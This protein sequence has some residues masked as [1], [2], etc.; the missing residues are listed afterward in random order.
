MLSYDQVCVERELPE[1]GVCC[2]SL[3]A[4][5]PAVENT[6]NFLVLS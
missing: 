6:F 1:T 2:M 5:A 3:A 4:I